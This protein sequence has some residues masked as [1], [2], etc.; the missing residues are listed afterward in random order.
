MRTSPPV[1]AIL[2]DKDGTLFDFARSWYRWASGM[3]LHFARGDEIRASHVAETIGIDW[4][5]RTFYPWCPIIHGIP[6]ELLSTLMT[7]FPGWDR[8]TMTEY[9]YDTSQTAEMVA[10]IPLHPLLESLRN[11]GLILG[12]ATNDYVDIARGQLQDHRVDHLFAYIA[13]SDSGYG[14]KPEPGMLLA[15]C[16]HTGIPPA[17]TLMV[18]DTT[19]DMLAARAAGMPAMAVRNGLQDIEALTAHADH[20]LASIAELPTWL[21]IEDAL[22]GP[23]NSDAAPR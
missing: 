2:F 6:T 20:S 10:Y 4:Q 3:L 19:A 15:F 17:E 5:N 7:A 16:Q 11:S 12:V 23:G 18:G 21:Q 9:I 14:S 13:G 8:E 22:T 1:R